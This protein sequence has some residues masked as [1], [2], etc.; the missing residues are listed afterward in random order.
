MF[1]VGE[2]FTLA[3]GFNRVQ[4][5]AAPNGR[6][7][8]L[9]PASWWLQSYTL[10]ST[11]KR[12]GLEILGLLRMDGVGVTVLWQGE[13]FQGT[14]IVTMIYPRPIQTQSGSPRVWIEFDASP[15]DGQVGYEMQAVLYF[16]RNP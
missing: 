2:E 13:H 12:P 9:V 5:C 16:T 1:V 6:S 15:G 10:T 3:P 11:S 7:C 14:F 4:G 8:I